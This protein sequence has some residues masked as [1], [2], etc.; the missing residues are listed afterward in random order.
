M[1]ALPAVL[2]AVQGLQTKAGISQDAVVGITCGILALLF[3]L[4]QFGTQRVG[5]TFAPTILLF[6]G[7]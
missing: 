6:F 4:Q 3:C 7:G 1:H 5:S 2:S